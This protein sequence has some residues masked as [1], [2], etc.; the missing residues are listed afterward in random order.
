MELFPT[1][2]I[3]EV[4]TTHLEGFDRTAYLICPKFIQF[5]VTS[6]NL[7]KHQVN[8]AEQVEVFWKRTG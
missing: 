5:L 7:S 2:E 6:P 3:P 1:L 8:L 4:N